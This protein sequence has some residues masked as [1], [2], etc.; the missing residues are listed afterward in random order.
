MIVKQIREIGEIRGIRVNRK[1]VNTVIGVLS[2]LILA[3]FIWFDWKIFVRREIVLDK[4]PIGFYQ[5]MASSGKSVRAYCT[6]G[7][8]D[9]LTAQKMGIAVLGG[10]NPVQLT[11]F[12]NYLQKAGGYT[13]TGYFPILPPYTIFSQQPQP[14]AELMAQTATKFVISPYE[15]KDDKLKLIDQ[16]QDYRLYQN[17]ADLAEYKDHYFSL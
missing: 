7:C 12:V 4:V 13:E 1:I 16:E 8:L 3:E 9:R 15:L 11:S 5:I 14:N 10:N 2:G 6:T 17:I